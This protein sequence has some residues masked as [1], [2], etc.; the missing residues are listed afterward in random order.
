MSKSLVQIAGWTAVIAVIVGG[1]VYAFRPVPVEVDVALVTRGRMEVA[2]EEE[3]VT[4]IREKYVISSPLAGRMSR[5]ELHAGDLVEGGKTVLLRIDP[6]DPSL[7]DARQLAEAKARLNAAEDAAGEA[8]PA[9][10]RAKD[11]LSHA[12]STYA[13]VKQL[14]GT[15][16]VSQQE[17]EN[18]QYELQ[19]RTHEVRST[20]SALLVAQHE[21][22]L[23]R[24]AMLRT[25][26]DA[27]TQG[28][29]WNLSISAPV[30]GRVL[31]VLKESAG[32]VSPGMPLLEIGDPAD[33][34]VVVD[35]LSSDAVQITRGAKAQ[36]VAWG[37]PRPLHAHVR[38]VEPSGFTKVSSLGVEEQRV[39]CVLDLEDLPDARAALGD[40]YRVEARIV[41]WENE[42]VV[43][44]P[45]SAF[46]W[47]RDRWIVMVSVDQRAA[48]REVTLGR[49]NR[50]EVEILDGLSEGEHVVVHPS[51]RVR[52]GVR[53]RE[54]R[55]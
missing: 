43:K 55:P 34:D 39:N 29:D 54:T 1:L 25:N 26:P 6:V 45:A 51:D 14:V 8:E 33:L 9:L 12:Q 50:D 37:E 13:R 31:K 38:L 15:K 52:D 30:N 23:A 24:A 10:A 46:F 49:R 16:A 28:E 32:V 19:A 4:R 18:A 20:E 35:V 21:L 3:G 22:E 36:L 41:T 11:A 40:A 17:Y 48:E 7:L 44:A 47:R 27:N 42:D 2:I 5:V 53:L